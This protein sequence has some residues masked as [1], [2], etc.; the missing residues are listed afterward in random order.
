METTMVRVIIK[1]TVKIRAT[2]KLDEEGSEAIF[3]AGPTIVGAA[4]AVS[5]VDN[6][7]ADGDNVLC[8]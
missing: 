8:T 3:K 7:V 1:D 6:E 2:F 5:I 4:M